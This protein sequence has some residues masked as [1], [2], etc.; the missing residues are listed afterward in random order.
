MHKW[1]GH[2]FCPE[3]VRAKIGAAA[4]KVIEDRYKVT[5]RDEAFKWCKMDPPK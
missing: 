3:D 4:K 2:V 1:R 5:V